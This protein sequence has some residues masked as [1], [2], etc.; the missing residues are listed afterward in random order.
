MAKNFTFYFPAPW[1]ALPVGAKVV[2]T[3]LKCLEQQQATAAAAQEVVGSPP[4]LST[5]RG[6]TG[7]ILSSSQA[8]LMSSPSMASCQEGWTSTM[9]M[10]IQ[11]KEWASST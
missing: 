11:E 4:D 10:D 2:A 1:L 9:S 7:S 5:G 3:K 8:G 6:S